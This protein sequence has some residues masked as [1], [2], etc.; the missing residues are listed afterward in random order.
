[1]WQ[2]KFFFQ[3]LLLEKFLYAIRIENLRGYDELMEMTIR[4]AQ[5]D[6]DT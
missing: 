5:A 1:M 2:K 4:H 6:H 3:A